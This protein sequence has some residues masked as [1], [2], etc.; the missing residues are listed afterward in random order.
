MKGR[1]S[2]RLIHAYCGGIV[3]ARAERDALATENGEIRDL[4]RRLADAL[5]LVTSRL[6]EYRASAEYDL[7]D[8]A[9]EKG[10]LP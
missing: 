1:D 3:T 5:R 2:E 9:R 10:L 8:E 4:A 6:D 7:L